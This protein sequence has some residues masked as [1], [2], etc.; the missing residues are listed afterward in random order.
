MRRAAALR[1]GLINGQVSPCDDPEAPRPPHFE[2]CYRISL[3]KEAQSMFGRQ[4]LLENALAQIEAIS[5]SQAIIEFDLNG[6]IITANEN[7]LDALGYSLDE[8]RGRHHSIFVPPSDQGAPYKEFWARLNHGEYQAAQYRRIKKDGSSIWIQA[9]YNPILDRAGKPFKVV[10]FATDVTAQV[11]KAREDAGKIAAIDRAQAIIEFSPDGTIL[12][13]NDNFLVTMGYSLDEI[14]GKHHSMFVEP[15]VRQGSAYKEAWAKL[16]RGEFLTGEFKRLGKNGKEVWILASY[17]P[18]MDE[19]GKP[20]KV[21]KFASDVTERKLLAA[22]TKGQIDAIR[23][24]QAV[25]EFGMDGTILWA[26]QNFLDTMK[27]SLAEIKGRHHS[28]FIDAA[29]RDSFAYGKFWERLN[30]GEY[31]AGEF[32]RIGRGGF[33]PPTIPSS[34]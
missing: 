26:N 30:R 27:Y 21:V 25:I 34:I 23:K 5:R 2:V 3:P 8:I 12:G 1:R 33:R 18:I 24:S 4:K 28:M 11:A 19:T 15:E 29:E 16:N 22:D 32:K 9:S 6:T 13:A 17:N 7:F 31:Q 10:K 20:F 14:G